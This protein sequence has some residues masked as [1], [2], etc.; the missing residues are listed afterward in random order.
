[1]K[2]TCLST[3]PYLKLLSVWG[4]LFFSALLFLIP[5]LRSFRTA[6]AFLGRPVL[7]YKHIII[8]TFWALMYIVDLCKA[9][10]M[11]KFNSI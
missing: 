1:M 11:L 8:S 9:W 5:S 10:N 6:T 4:F 3:L 7:D 2:M